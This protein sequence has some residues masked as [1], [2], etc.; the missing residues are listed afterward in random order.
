MYYRI[1]STC[2]PKANSIP[3]YT[4]A[5]LATK[6]RVRNAEMSVTEVKAWVATA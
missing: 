2:P 4:V 1:S 6:V 3:T 5:A